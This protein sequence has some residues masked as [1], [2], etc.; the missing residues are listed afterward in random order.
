MELTPV[1]V[2]IVIFGFIYG[3]VHLGVRRKERMAM[4]NSGADPSIFQQSKPAIAGIRYGLLLIGV[5]VGILLGNILEVTT[6]LD[7]EVAYFSM[8]FLLGGLALVISYFVERH[9]RDKEN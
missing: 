8:I 2:L 1:L 9:Q 6:C 5:A 7:E 3:I 4:I